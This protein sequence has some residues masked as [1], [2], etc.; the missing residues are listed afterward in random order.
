M[1]K[2]IDGNA[3]DKYPKITNVLPTKSVTDLNFSISNDLLDDWKY[4]TIPII[5]VK[6]KIPQKI[7][8]EKL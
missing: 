1:K 2:L 6:I 4:L 8:V 3:E 7:F 5:S